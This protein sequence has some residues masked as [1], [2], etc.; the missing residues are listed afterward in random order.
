MVKLDNNGVS[1]SPGRSNRKSAKRFGALLRKEYYLPILK[2]L[3]DSG[4]LCDIK[5]IRSEIQARMGHLFQ[6][7]DLE[8]IGG[9][10]PFPHEWIYSVA[11]SLTQLKRDK[12]VI[13]IA[14]GEWKLTSGGQRRLLKNGVI[15]YDELIPDLDED[16]E[17]EDI[18]EIEVDKILPE[19]KEEKRYYIINIS[20]KTPNDGF[21][22]NFQRNIWVVDQK[23][24]SINIGDYLITHYTNKNLDPEYQEE[25]RDQYNKFKQVKGAIRELY[26]IIE[27]NEI[28]DSKIELKIKMEE[29]LERISNED[30]LEL[31][32]KEEIW[33]HIKD[34]VLDS[35]KI[36]LLTVEESE[37]ILNYEP[38]ELET[39]NKWNLLDQDLV[40]HELKLDN[41]QLLKKRICSALNANKHLILIGPPG[42]GKT[43]IA[44]YIAE[45]AKK[46]NYCKGYTLTTATSDWTTFDT[47]GGLVPKEDANG[48]EF[49]PGQFLQT[50]QKNHMLIIDEI[51]RADIDK[52]FG[53]LFTI[54]SGQNLELPYY[55]KD[56]SGF[57]QLMNVDELENSFTDSSYLVGENWR[58]IATMNSYDKTSL[59]EM[60]FAFMRRFAFI[61]IDTPQKRET[62]VKILND[63]LATHVITPKLEATILNFWE[64][65]DDLRKVGPAIFKDIIEYIVKYGPENEDDEL[66]AFLDGIVAYIVPQL[67]G[68]DEANLKEF[69]E[70]VST[71]FE[72]PELMPQFKS[73]F[74]EF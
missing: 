34:K 69:Y 42:T 31:A 45:I 29:E 59:Y 7:S 53:Q 12:L 28:S 68:L 21:I 60:S 57:I 64:K 6:K 52:A 36:I 23:I 39:L 27:M 5:L 48:L 65:T 10:R 56:K 41:E 58:I 66:N 43:S 63:F 13:S 1:N 71:T 32:K 2:V 33:T 37:T 38:I 40:F 22:G 47:I 49:R 46:N 24:Y 8:P 62:R 18:T 3:H 14:R 30:L 26:E 67:E 70:I 51:N 50:I 15:T 20:N 54:L 73:I 72:K 17:T 11:W 74:N 25:Y 61:Y 35:K 44:I 4:G 9:T 16:V 55:N 19:L